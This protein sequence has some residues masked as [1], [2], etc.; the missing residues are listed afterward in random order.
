[1]SKD[2]ASV[3]GD[4]IIS[5]MKRVGFARLVL[6][7]GFFQ[8][9]QHILTY[10]AAKRVGFASKLVLVTPVFIDIDRLLIDHE[11]MIE[12]DHADINATIKEMTPTIRYITDP[13]AV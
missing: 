12:L 3:I 6:I 1:M 10:V 4:Q 11:T 5:T 9:H 8:R 2:L 7:Y 13:N